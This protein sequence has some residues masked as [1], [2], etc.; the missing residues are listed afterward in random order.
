MSTRPVRGID[1]IGVGVGAVI[2]ND[3]DEVL[4][5]LRRKSPEAGSWSIPGGGVEWQETCQDAIVRECIEEVGVSVR[6]ERFLTVVNH[7]VPEDRMHWVSIEFL[8]SVV[9]GHARN[10]GEQESSDLRWFPF[11]TLPKRL[12]QPS[13]EAIQAFLSSR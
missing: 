2:V 5:L 3:R 12:S 10:V 11:S 13:R 9:E 7:I 6:V 1:Y 8:C 4:L